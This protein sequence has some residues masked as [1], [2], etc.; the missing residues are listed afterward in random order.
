M[1]WRVWK[2]STVLGPGSFKIMHK[3]KYLKNAIKIWTKEVGLKDEKDINILMEELATLKQLD[4]S[5]GLVQED[6]N[7]VNEKLT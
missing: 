2:N 5:S 6:K 4:G 1:V 7:R 3:L